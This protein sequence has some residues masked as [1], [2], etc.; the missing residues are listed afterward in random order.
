MA[1]EQ[2]SYRR[3][4]SAFVD[5]DLG[6]LRRELEDLGDFPNASP[7][8]AIGMP[9]VY[10]VYHSPLAFVRELLESGADPDGTEGD[11]FPPLIAALT[12]TIPAPGAVVRHD[13][14]E[15]VGLLLTWGADTGQRG[16]KDETPLH[17]AAEQGNLAAV[18]LLLSHGAD[19]NQITRIDDMETP[20]EMAEQAG[21]DAVV[22][23]LRPLTTR[24]GW[25][26]AAEIGDL[27][28]LQRMRRRGHDVDAKDGYGLTALMRASHAGHLESVEWLIAEGAELDHTSKF[29]L[30][31]LMLAVIGGHDEVVQ[32]LADAGA[33]IGIEGSGAPGFS[34]KTAADL[35]EESGKKRLAAH[36]RRRDP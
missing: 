8:L 36:L 27:L 20:L 12:S 16:P 19:P 21:H 2:E 10:A 4:H 23:R 26:H 3:I 6:A 13:V 24:L 32:K 11:G 15:L 5:G 25:E 7:D 34:G 35:A 22:D 9:L 33:D 30:S 14:L 1:L 29:H 18:E 28:E 17:L 31:G